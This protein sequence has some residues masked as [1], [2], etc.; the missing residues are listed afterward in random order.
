M[1]NSF[2]HPQ[3]YLL[4]QHLFNYLFENDDLKT[5]ERGLKVVFNKEIKLINN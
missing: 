4:P 3:L 5:I 2:L 1:E